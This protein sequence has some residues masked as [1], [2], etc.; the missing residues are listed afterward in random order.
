MPKHCQ[1]AFLHCDKIL[2][3]HQLKEEVFIWLTDSGFSLRQPGSIAFGF[4]KKGEETAHSVGVSRQKKMR[5][6]DRERKG[7]REGKR[8]TQEREGQVE[9]ERGEKK[10]DRVYIQSQT[11]FCVPRTVPV[12]LFSFLFVPTCAHISQRSIL[13]IFLNNFPP[14][15]LRGSV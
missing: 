11:Y 3:T 8:E 6:K 5:C 9:E 10:K 13:E 7:Q 14:Q 4:K 2:E 12:A 15:F 1:L